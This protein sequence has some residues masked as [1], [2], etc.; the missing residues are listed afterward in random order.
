MIYYWLIFFGYIFGL[1]FLFKSLYNDY[2]I[3]EIKNFFQMQILNCINE[4]CQCVLNDFQY[5]Y[6]FY[7]NCQKLDYFKSLF[8]WYM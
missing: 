1:Q 6:V 5:Y 8:G 2:N 7:N 3:K 4:S